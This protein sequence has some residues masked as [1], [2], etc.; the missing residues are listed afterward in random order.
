MELYGVHPFNWSCKKT[1]GHF[2][3]S[4]A[5]AAGEQLARVTKS[6]ETLEEQLKSLVDIASSL[7]PSEVKESTREVMYNLL[8]LERDL[9]AARQGA[10]ITTHHHSSLVHTSPIL[11]SCPFL[12]SSF[13]SVRP[14]AFLWLCFGSSWFSTSKLVGL[15][16]W[17]RNK[18]D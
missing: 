18:Q 1:F 7:E 13:S 6:I 3:I 4:L 8:A 2:L 16:F 14:L 5:M 12:F 15:E 9:E 11:E 10:L 17:L